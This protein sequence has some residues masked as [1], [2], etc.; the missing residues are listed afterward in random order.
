MPKFL[1]LINNTF[2]KKPQK[3]KIT[4]AIV[5]GDS[6]SDTGN[7]STFTYQATGG[8]FWLPPSPPLPGPGSYYAKDPYYNS[9]PLGSPPKVRVTNGFNWVDYLSTDLKL[10]T[11]NFAYAGATTGTTNGLQPMF[12]PGFPKL[13]GLADQISNF[14][15]STGTRKADPKGLYVIWAG[16]N[17]AFNLANPSML[18][19]TDLAKTLSAITSTVTTAINN[20][21]ND[22]AIL[23]NA[24]ARVFL[25][26]NLPDL[27]AIPFL[28]QNQTS[29]FIGT[30]FSLAFNIKLAVELPKLE[31]SLKIDIVQPDVYTLFQEV[32]RRPQ[33]F[34][35]KN[36]TDPLIGKDPN[37]TLVKP[38][39]FLFYDTQHPTTAGHK[40]IAN[41]FQ[42]SLFQAGYVN[43]GASEVLP[44]PTGGLF[45]QEISLV[46]TLVNG[47]SGLQ[48]KDLVQY[49]SW[50]I[51]DNFGT[52]S[53]FTRQYGDTLGHQLILDS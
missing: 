18:P 25:V 11:S 43:Q 2:Y 50:L 45:E 7:L 17:D 24:G 19:S 52:A 32:I 14:T 3:T 22:L 1:R 29:A 13:P 44:R 47:I 5:F 21:K 33:E 31:R 41:L 53:L 40:W 23:A 49:L 10:P 12:P 46:G 39:E 15:T 30:V 16:A 36:V 35:F 6:L 28:K 27:G 38:D 42:D 37:D 20:I 9:A 48:P 8:Q 34:G 26:P 4:S 51:P